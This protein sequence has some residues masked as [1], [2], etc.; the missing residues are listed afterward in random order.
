MSQTIVGEPAVDRKV[1]ETEVNDSQ[2]L[3]AS[4]AAEQH[5]GYDRSEPKMGAIALWGLVVIVSLIAVV[6]GVQSYF[7]SVNQRQVFTRVVQPVAE[8]LTDIRTKENA[9]LHSYQWVDADA[10]VVRL[11][12]DR[13]MELLVAEFAA[14]ELRY[15]TEPAP[16]KKPDLEPRP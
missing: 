3:V 8:D 6:L 4:H 2:S 7:D 1:E 12:I 9:R 11:P 5:A 16:V 14:G 13:G 15:S 10:G